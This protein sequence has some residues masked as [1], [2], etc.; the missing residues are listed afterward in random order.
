MS[1]LLRLLGFVDESQ[2]LQ[3]NMAERKCRQKLRL[4]LPVP[5]SSACALYRWNNISVQRSL[6]Y[7]PCCPTLVICIGFWTSL[8][9]IS[10]LHRLPSFLCLLQQYPSPFF[11]FWRFNSLVFCSSQ[12]NGA[13]EDISCLSNNS[14]PPI[15]YSYRYTQSLCTQFCQDAREACR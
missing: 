13:F 3:Q 11:S 14:M 1:V 15:G 8:S 9:L 12:N 10:C 2:N 6:V 5:L 4:L 7:R